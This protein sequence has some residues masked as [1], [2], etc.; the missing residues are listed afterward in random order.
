MARH[1][2][3]EI[4]TVTGLYRSGYSISSVSIQTGLSWNTIDRILRE[5]GG[6]D[7]PR[8]TITPEERDEAVGKV[9]SGTKSRC[10]ECRHLVYGR[11]RAC[12]LRKKLAKH[13]FPREPDL[14]PL[15]QSVPR[16]FGTGL[17]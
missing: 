8:E 16:H 5:N 2:N 1:T 9:E 3:H 6:K 14:H 10:P 17:D 7:V 4:A 15:D 12:S 13:Q 11:C